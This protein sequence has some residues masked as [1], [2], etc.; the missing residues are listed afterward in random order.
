MLVD[1]TYFTGH[2][3]FQDSWS[4]DNMVSS[5]GSRSNDNFYAT[6]IN[7]INII[8]KA[9]ISTDILFR[10]LHVLNESRDLIVHIHKS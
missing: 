10:N 1:V 6:D 2:L 8:S 3:N 9:T 7:I 5:D 4:T